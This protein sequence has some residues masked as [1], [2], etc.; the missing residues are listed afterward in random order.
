M[1]SYFPTRFQARLPVVREPVH[2]VGADRFTGCW[3]GQD[4]L[5][6][7]RAPCLPAVVTVIAFLVVSPA[8]TSTVDRGLLMPGE[9]R[10]GHTNNR[11]CI[12]RRLLRYEIEMP[13]ESARSDHGPE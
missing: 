6:G 5:L 11:P 3:V 4:S 2:V 10:P 12:Y 9:Q 1:P 7:T 13:K 8:I